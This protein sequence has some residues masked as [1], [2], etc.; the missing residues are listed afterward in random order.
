MH[1]AR[2]IVQEQIQQTKKRI[3]TVLI[4]AVSFIPGLLI[5]FNYKYMQQDRRFILL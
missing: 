1:F 4:F 5:L 2:E 3:L